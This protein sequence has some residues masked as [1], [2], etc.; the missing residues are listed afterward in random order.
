MHT[1]TINLHI[2]CMLS[3]DQISSVCIFYACYHVTFCNVY[4][5]FMLLDGGGKQ[6]RGRY[7]FICTQAALTVQLSLPCQMLTDIQFICTQAALTVLSSGCYLQRWA[8][9]L[10]T[11]NHYLCCILYIGCHIGFS[12]WRGLKQS[13][14]NLPPLVY[15]IYCLGIPNAIFP[16]KLW[17]LVKTPRPGTLLLIC[18][19]R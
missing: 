7:I 1:D 6:G 15:S 12:A 14:D 13:I 2:L 10:Q 4:S 17:Q 19:Y 8:S 16:L 9:H 11:S 3:C 5:L 18:Q